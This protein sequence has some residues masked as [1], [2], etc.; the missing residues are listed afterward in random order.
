MLHADLDRLA[1]TENGLSRY[2]AQTIRP[3]IT[4]SMQTRNLPGCWIH[5]VLTIAWLLDPSLAT[6][7]EDYLDVSLEGITRGMTCCY[8]RDTSTLGKEVITGKL[9]E[10]KAKAMAYA[11]KQARKKSA[12]A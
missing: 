2:L 3:W 4:Y 12:K 9:D 11:C 10:V 5:D 7:A 8:G 6:T 1:K